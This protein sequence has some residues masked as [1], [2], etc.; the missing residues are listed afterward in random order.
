MLR[1]GALALATQDL[2]GW[3]SRSPGC[4][5]DMLSTHPIIDEEFEGYPGCCLL[6]IAY[7]SSRLVGN[8][9]VLPGMPRGR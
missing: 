6:P 9:K 2:I 5:S 1:I 7:C 4:E 3:L 8:G